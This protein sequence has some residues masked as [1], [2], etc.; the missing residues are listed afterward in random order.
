MPRPK[1]PESQRQRAAEACRFCREAKKK[2]S[3]TAPCNQC[4]RRGL[5]P[6]CRM[7][8]LPRGSRTKKPSTMRA[9]NAAGRRSRA[10]LEHSS[11]TVATNPLGLSRT[12]SRRHDDIDIEQ[13]PNPFPM[14]PSL[15]QQESEETSNDA[16]QSPM[17][18]SRE[19]Q[20]VEDS[21]AESS[22][23]ANPSRLLRSVHGEQVFVGGA[24]AISFL[25]T[26]R[27]VVVRQIGPSPFSHNDGMETMLEAESP[28]ARRSILSEEAVDLGDQRRLDYLNCY[29]TITEG[30]IN[31]LDSDDQ[32]ELLCPTDSISV[33]VAS[34]V[35]ADQS[36][37]KAAWPSEHSPH[38]SDA[39]RDMVMAIGAQCSSAQEAQDHSFAFF[40][41][42][43]RQAFSG[44]LEDPDLDMVRVFLLMAFYMLGNCRRNTAYMYTS[45]A[46]RA[47]I[48]LGLHSQTM[49]TCEPNAHQCGLLK[50]RV[51]ISVRIL[52][53]LVS[54]LLGRP[55][56]TAG[57]EARPPVGD[58][59]PDCNYGSKYLVATCEIVG[60]INDIN[61]T[62][63]HGK[64]ITILVV[65]QLLVN[66]DG[67]RRDLL[68]PLE[69][70][71]QPEVLRGSVEANRVAVAKIHVSCLYYFSVTL[72]TR[73]IFI[74]SLNS[75][76]G[77]K[78]HHPPLAAACIEA[79]V[80]LA[81]TCADALKAGLL[82]RSMCI[83]KALVFSAGL[84]LGVECFAK[85]ST[86]LET[87]K[88]FQGAM[89]VL[90][91]LAG[92][93]PQAAHYLEILTS[94]ATAIAERRSKSNNVESSRYVSRLF[95]IESLGHVSG[96]NQ[97]GF[98]EREPSWAPNRT[99][100]EQ[101]PFDVWPGAD[102][103]LLNWSELQFDDSDLHIDWQSL[104]VI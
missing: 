77:N 47:A 84:I 16:R 2:C 78:I 51:W 81:Q 99:V 103:G 18:P 11:I 64:D 17:S 95:N 45:I 68:M 46:V 100:T 66:I 58:M 97:E 41:K 27:Q 71:K 53:K 55:A 79:A 30:L 87:D 57:T 32:K 92:Q 6:D 60:I 12:R 24:A 62:L 98:A 91:F 31:I 33:G 90:T 75:Q 80:Y 36:T 85:V 15:S 37:G 43:Q 9:T 69:C 70:A 88:A 21:R 67:W 49:Y 40:R 86:D 44:L 54:S 7:T 102:G 59:A 39:I 20:T 94:L 8:Y 22:L 42:A 4:V 19:T 28:E 35:E 5:E 26:V 82:E 10:S 56:A 29:Y 104:G 83:L 72:A 89:D 3:G 52:D 73:P 74:S 23:L 1:V 13:S 25:Q 96:N 65:E 34:P 38:L 101:G 48:A 61:N 63:Y 93:S 50:S 14:S 76:A